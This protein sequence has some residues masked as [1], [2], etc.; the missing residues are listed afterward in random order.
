MEPLALLRELLTRSYAP[1]SK[2]P[3]AALVRGRSGTF[4]GGVNVENASYPLSRC[5]EQNAVAAL[6][7]AGEREVLEVWVMSQGRL[8]AL[9]C[10]GCRQVLAEFAG[11]ETPIHCWLPD[12]LG[13]TYTL[14][15]LLPKAFR[16]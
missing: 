15:E 1:Y 16:L 4:Y 12:G 6:V 8:P 2:F 9:P 5:A 10:G 7:A 11:P 3:V 13:P 14:G